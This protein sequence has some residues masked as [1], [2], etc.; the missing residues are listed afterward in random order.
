MYCFIY[1][2]YCVGILKITDASLYVELATGTWEISIDSGWQTADTIHS[3]CYTGFAGT[4]TKLLLY[5]MIKS[6]LVID[7]FS[8]FY[9]SSS[10]ACSV[11]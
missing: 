5:L 2:I 3:V 7:R 9:M 1:R 8:M 10:M 6:C 4:T 11:P